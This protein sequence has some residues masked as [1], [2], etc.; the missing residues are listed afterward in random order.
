VDAI[1]DPDTTAVT[2]TVTEKGYVCRPGSHDLDTTDP[3]IRRDATLTEPPATALGLMAAGLLRRLDHGAPL[4]LVSCDNVGHNGAGLRTVMEQYASLLPSAQSRALLG[5]LAT[6]GTPDTMVDRIVPRTTDATRAAV[7]RA[8]IV[9]AVPV[10]AEPFSMWVIDDTFSGPRPAWE[11]AGAILSDEVGAY[12]LVKLRLLNALNSMLAYLGLLTGRTEIADA[13]SDA[14]I[15]DIAD[16]GLRRDA[17]DHRSPHRLRPLRIPRRGLCPVPQPRAG[18][19]LP[20][21]RVRRLPQADPART[22]RR[23]LARSLRPH[24]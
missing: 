4:H 19:R 11:D 3:A 1:A 23:R 15:R 20:A 21:G 8:G 22:R 9:D 17:A 5:Y 12:E 16:R 6:V 13:A 2:L 24:P 10:P 14:A 18:L 7:A